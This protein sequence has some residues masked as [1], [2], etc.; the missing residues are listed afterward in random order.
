MSLGDLAS[1]IGLLAA[2]L[3]LLNENDR[4]ILLAPFQATWVKVLLGITVLC[5]AYLLTAETWV[6]LHVAIPC[7]LEWNRSGYNLS[8]PQ[9]GVL[10]FVFALSLV[11]GRKCFTKSSG[12]EIWAVL[13]D[14][15]AIRG[16]DYI[17][18][19]MPRF[20][21]NRQ[22][23]CGLKDG[24]CQFLANRD[25]V[26]RC[27]HHRPQILVDILTHLEGDRAALWIRE[28]LF[29]FASERTAI[30]EDW[31]RGEFFK[32]EAVLRP[33]GSLFQWM[34]KRAN[35]KVWQM[36]LDDLERL[37]GVKDGWKS[38]EWLSDESDDHLFDLPCGRLAISRVLLAYECIHSDGELSGKWNDL[39]GHLESVI[40]VLLRE[41]QTTCPHENALTTWDDQ[42]DAPLQ[43]K[44]S[45]QHAGVLCI[46]QILMVLAKGRYPENSPESQSESLQ[47]LFG[48]AAVLFDS[49][50]GLLSA[51]IIGEVSTSK[52]SFIVENRKHGLAKRLWKH[53]PEDF[54]KTADMDYRARLDALRAG[55]PESMAA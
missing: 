53:R 30:L 19:R 29:V 14:Q 1:L 40:A 28:A 47:A 8:G 9:W 26:A 44:P 34:G 11:A 4:R 20:L 38:R 35:A 16:Y 6:K 10:P 22:F 51:E 33:K 17:L 45:G 27:L 48:A 49:G 46:S 21:K 54:G 15:W 5:Q 24:K 36:L 25:F 52:L 13:Q 55:F 43:Q 23:L 41:F 31:L 2:A 12:D 7:V 39:G 32:E 37:P 42:K 50:N 3:A 18:S